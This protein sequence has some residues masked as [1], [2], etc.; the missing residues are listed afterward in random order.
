MSKTILDVKNKKKMS[1]LRK[2]GAKGVAIGYKITDGKI[3]DEPAIIVNVEKKLPKSQLKSSDMVPSKIKGFNTDVVEL[4]KIV[5]LDLDTQ[6]K[7]RPAPCGVSIGHKNITA[8][9]LGCVVYKDGVPFILSNN[10]VLA[11]S[12]AAKIN[13]EI[14][15]PGPYDGGTLADQI[16]ALAHFVPIDFGGDVEPPPP[17]EDPPGEDPPTPPPDD[18]NGGGCK[19][20]KAFASFG[21]FMA[22]KLGSSYVVKLEKFST[23]NYVDAALAGPIEVGVDVDDNIVD[24]GKIVGVRMEPQLLLDIKKFGRTTHFTEDRILQLHADIQ[25]GYGPGQTALFEDQ[26]VAG[27]M[28]AGGDSGSIVLDMDNQVVGLLFA[29]S[30]Y[31]TIINPIKYVIQALDITF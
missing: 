1:L 27:P 8:G 14:L 19:I 6:K 21:N 22:S 3:T 25:V 17:D 5:A 13:D 10:H 2:R 20:A 31:A 30:D 7:Y 11:N 18:G 12:N 15:Q 29:G 9:T 23:P 26:I 4:G 24:I 16:S 28:S